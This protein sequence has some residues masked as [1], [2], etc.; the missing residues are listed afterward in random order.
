[1]I[2]ESEREF[3]AVVESF[4]ERKLR[5]LATEHDIAQQLDGDLVARLGAIG[6]LGMRVPVAFGGGGASMSATV[7]ALEAI[8]R[9][10]T[11]FAAS[12]IVHMAV[13]SVISHVGTDEQRSTYL[14]LVA[15]GAALCGMA[16][17]E[18]E[19]GS[20]VRS[21]R[22]SAI[23]DGSVYRLNGEKVYI[24]NGASASFLIV[25]ATLGESRRLVWFIVER[26][27]PGLV[28]TG[29]LDKLGVRASETV[30]LR[31]EDCVVDASRLL[32][33]DPEADGFVAGHEAMNQDRLLGAAVAVGLAARAL[34]EAIGYTTTRRQFGQPVAQFQAVRHLLAD[35][36]TETEAGR[37]LVR[38]AANRVDC[39][40]PYATQAAMAKLYTGQV[41]RRVCA[42]ALELHGGS[43]FMA[44]AAISRLYRDAPI[45]SI[46]GG[47]SNMQRELIGRALVTGVQ[48]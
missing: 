8:S 42:E 37:A 14:P 16:I 32:G 5:P 41:V 10:N 7:N 29:K 28:V 17:T 18:P 20:D 46:A 44:E 24:T 47:T 15:E 34:E 1:M 39:G 23:P 11:G 30:T 33:G 31:F 26:D 36:A 40:E 9:A 25:A 43:G 12:L 2:T 22:T 27:D 21:L 4:A 45:M 38:T 35:L 19:A 48:R 3:L 13:G 6:A